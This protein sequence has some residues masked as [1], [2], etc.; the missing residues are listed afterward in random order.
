MDSDGDGY[1]DNQ[2]VFPEDSKDWV[3]SDGDGCGDNTDLWPN[4]PQECGDRDGD[5]FG[6]R[7]DAFP[8]NPS[9]WFDQDGDGIGDNFDVDPF[10]PELRTPEDLARQEN[11]RTV[12]YAIITIGLL[13]LIFAA[14]AV[15]FYIRMEEARTRD[16]SSLYDSVTE[17]S[18]PTTAPPTDMF[19]GGTVSSVQS[20]EDVE[21]RLL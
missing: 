14:V 13:A 6:D 12:T 4:N 10:D 1:G 19:T 16:P 21:S 5:G 8:D 17:F 15:V 3:D 11:E 2:D 7:M 18:V 20:D 9:E